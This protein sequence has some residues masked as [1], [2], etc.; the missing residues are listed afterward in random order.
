VPAAKKDPL[1]QVFMALADP[2]RRQL[3]HLL[4]KNEMTMSELAANF[5]MSLAAVSKHVKVLEKAGLIS[6]RVEG[7][8]HTIGLKPEQLTQALDWISVY[9]NFWRKRID[10]LSQLIENQEE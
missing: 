4:A 3:V 5:E 2:S 7:R 6:R 9:R 8:V 1:D 10:R